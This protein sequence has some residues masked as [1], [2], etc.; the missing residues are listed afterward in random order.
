[1]VD[2]RLEGFS[3]HDL[4]TIQR[5]FD[6]PRGQINYGAAFPLCAPDAIVL[7]VASS[8]E[9]VAARQ[10]EGG[11]VSQYL[12]CVRE[13]VEALPQDN[14]VEGAAE[15]RFL[16]EL[17]WCTGTLVQCDIYASGSMPSTVAPASRK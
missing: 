5:C 3:R 8:N 15:Y 10:D 17:P 9:Q 7:C 16:G 2:Q 4:E 6:L 14:Q 11:R 12:W 13:V 1:M